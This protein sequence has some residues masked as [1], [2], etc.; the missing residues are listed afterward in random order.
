[1]AH[2]NTNIGR[3]PAEGFLFDIIYIIRLFDALMKASKFDSI[4]LYQM[5]Q[6]GWATLPY[7]YRASI[8]LAEREGFEPS[9]RIETRTTV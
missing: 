6:K 8:P 5:S 2:T 3:P 1:M 9:V 7:F 4:F